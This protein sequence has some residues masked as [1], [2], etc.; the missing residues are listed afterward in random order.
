MNKAK[1][2]DGIDF[3]D[4][5][6]VLKLHF[7]R[8]D[9]A[10]T[11]RRQLSPSFEFDDHA[12]K[13]FRHLRDCFGIDN[14]EYKRSLSGLYDFEAFEP[15]SDS[16]Q[17]FLFSHDGRYMI[18]T[19]SRF[20]AAFLRRI[21]PHYLR[22]V[23]A[24]PRT[25][26]PRFYGLHR[27][28]RPPFGRVTHFTVMHSVFDSSRYTDHM[29]AIYDLK[30]CWVGR[31]ASRSDAEFLRSMQIMDHSLLVGVRNATSSGDV[32]GPHELAGLPRSHGPVPSMGE[33][34]KVGDEV[35]YFGII[36]M[37]QPYNFRKRLETLGFTLIVPRQGTA[38][39]PPGEYADRFVNFLERHLV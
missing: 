33:D 13:V 39:L 30:G 7:R 24:N 1:A 25:F 20:E 17:S 15:N 12:P 23:V 29:T 21:L 37:L 5:N 9:A 2:V 16:G 22:Y 36:D 28:K 38:C 3:Q 10:A 8:G 32:R 14:D 26:L 34:G 19:Q 27:I 18:K 6:S 31:A 11:P 4:F 35:Y